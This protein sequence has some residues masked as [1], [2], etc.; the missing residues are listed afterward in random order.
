MPIC[1]F[2]IW[3]LVKQ[4]KHVL[5]ASWIMA[6]HS[7]ILHSLRTGFYSGP[8]A[9]AVAEAVQ[10]RRGV[11]TEA[12]LAAHR[13]AVVPPISTVYKGHRVYE[14]PPPTQVRHLLLTCDPLAVQRQLAELL[15]G[16]CCVDGVRRC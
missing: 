6:Q 15:R 7:V 14:V 16:R 9:A 13:S 8:V 12:D 2:A 10:S 3:Q 5:F 1:V 11:L 4:G